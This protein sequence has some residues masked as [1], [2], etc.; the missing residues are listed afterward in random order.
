MV[1]QWQYMTVLSF[2]RGFVT[3]KQ[4]HARADEEDL[5]TAH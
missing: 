4:H 3:A 1:I 5:E 2:A